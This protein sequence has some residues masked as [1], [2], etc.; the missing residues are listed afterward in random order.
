MP[1]TADL[2]SRTT[3]W[4][5]WVIVAAALL[6]GYLFLP[7]LLNFLASCLVRQDPLQ[8]ADVVIAMG[9]GMPCYRPQY[10]VELYRQRLAPKVVVSGLPAEW[11]DDAQKQTQRALMNFGAAE[12]DIIFVDDTLNT[13]R[14]ADGLVELMRAQGWK[15][16][17][18]VTDPYHTRRATYTLEKAAPDLKFY[19]APVPQGAG[20][21]SSQRWWTRRGDVYST[22]RELIAWA[23]TL[24]GGL[25]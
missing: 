12:A 8:P 1:E 7:V 14:E 11:G 17:L 18:I 16:A 19:A 21:W 15:S 20:I 24:V 22:L 23:N 25:R 4:R 9:G 13:R 10:A 6:L 5:R 3:R 2:H